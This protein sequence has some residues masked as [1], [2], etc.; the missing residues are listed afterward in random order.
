MTQEEQYVLLELEAPAG[1]NGEAKR[2]AGVS[3]SYFGWATT[4]CRE[5]HAL[6]RGEL[7]RNDES[8][9]GQRDR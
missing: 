5:R 2:L 1:V 3:W 7:Q 6:G 8:G 4:R 9:D